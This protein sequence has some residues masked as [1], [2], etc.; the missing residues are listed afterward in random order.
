MKSELRQLRQQ[1]EDLL[2]SSREAASRADVAHSELLG[3]LRVK[4]FELTRVQVSWQYVIDALSLTA[5]KSVL[6][7]LRIDHAEAAQPDLAK[8]VNATGLDYDLNLF[9]PPVD[10]NTCLA[11][12]CCC[13]VLC[14]I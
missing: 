4:Q 5:N 12:W 13:T 11:R 6:L 14:L 8:R 9:E 10:G 2:V 3:E 1:H 7:T